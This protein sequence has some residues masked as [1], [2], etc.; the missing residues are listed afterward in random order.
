MA[1][2]V[3]SSMS[4][5]CGSM[6]SA[7]AGDR[8]NADASNHS[9]PST[10]L[11]YRVRCRDTWSSDRSC[12]SAAS[13]SHR[14]RGTKLAVLAP[15]RRA[16]QSCAVPCNPP[17]ILP[18][19]PTIPSCGPVPMSAP[20]LAPSLTFAAAILD[21][22]ISPDQLPSPASPSSDKVASS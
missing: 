14:S 19:M 21:A 11:P 12:T 16:C 17:G 6:T 13:A 5:C 22:C 2:A 3:A 20:S 1:R 10:K 9:R 4:R 18:L 8:R 15:E 7:S